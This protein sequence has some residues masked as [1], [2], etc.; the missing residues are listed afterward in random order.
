M[1]DT[2]CERCVHSVESYGKLLCTAQNVSRPTEYM[3][4][5]QSACGPNALLFDPPGLE[6]MELEY[7]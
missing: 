1:T 3:R 4:H 6:D 5:P 2:Y 7:L